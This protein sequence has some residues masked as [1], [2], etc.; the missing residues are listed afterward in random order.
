MCFYLHLFIYYL[1]HKVSW[2]DLRRTVMKTDK[3]YYPMG[4]QQKS[5]DNDGRCTVVQV[6][7]EIIV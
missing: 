1:L 5:N 7:R 4:N 3:R 2:Q 6:R